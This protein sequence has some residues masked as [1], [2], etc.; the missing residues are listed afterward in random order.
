VSKSK[1][2]M[3]NDALDKI[4]DVITSRTYYFGD[5]W[6]YTDFLKNLH[7]KNVEAASVLSNVNAV[8]AVD[9]NHASEILPDNVHIIKT[10]PSLLDTMVQDLAKNNV[11][12]DVT[13]V[14]QSSLFDKI[15]PIVQWVGFYFL[16]VLAVNAFRYARNNA[17]GGGDTDSSAGTGNPFSIMSINRKEINAEDVKVRFKD[18]AGCEESKAELT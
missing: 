4:R 16:I 10:I 11:L 5:E 2:L 8:V 14:D 7:N 1:I 13:K 18:V 17:L 15:P 12:F 3:S 9:K 6:T